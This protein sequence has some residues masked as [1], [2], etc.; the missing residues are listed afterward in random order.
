MI[1]G[2]A[3]AAKGVASGGSYV[4]LPFKSS[5]SYVRKAHVKQINSLLFNIHTNALATCSS[6][7]CW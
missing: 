2:I 5:S 4:E 7:T 6:F 1:E 3:K